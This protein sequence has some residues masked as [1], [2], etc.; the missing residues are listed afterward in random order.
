MGCAL[1]L[2]PDSERV[3]RYAKSVALAAGAD[4][5]LIHVIEDSKPQSKTEGDPME[6]GKRCRGSPNSRVV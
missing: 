3:L 6:K 1:A 4:L 2:S 5:S